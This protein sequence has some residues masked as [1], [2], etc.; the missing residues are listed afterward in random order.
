MNVRVRG[1]A[2]ARGISHSTALTAARRAEELGALGDAPD[3]DV[4]VVDDL[5]DRRTRL[6]LVPAD[7]EASR[8][9]AVAAFDGAGVAPLSR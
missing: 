5:L 2:A 8:G 3:I 7:A 4:L 1:D 9:A 6:G